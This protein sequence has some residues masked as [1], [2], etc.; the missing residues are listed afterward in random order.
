MPTQHETSNEPKSTVPSAFISYS[1]DS[2]EHREWVRDL[3]AQLRT[4]GVN[5]IL[6]RWHAVPGDQLPEFMER[7]IRENDYV[8]IVCTPKYKEKSDGRKG[9]VGYE[10]D[11]MTAE[12]FTTQNN[13]KFIPLLRMGEWRN[14]APSWLGGKYHIDLRGKP[15]SEEHYQDLLVT[16]HGRREQAPPI[17]AAPSMEKSVKRD[18]TTQPIPKSDSPDPS[19][20]ITIL[21]VIVDDITVPR[22]DG[23][24][25]SGLYAIPFRLSRRPTSEWS[26]M[27]IETWNHPP[28]FT[29]MH[30]PGIARVEGD[31][32]VLDGTTIDEVEEYHRDTLKLVVERTN[33]LALEHERIK[34]QREEQERQR[35]QTHEQKIKEAANRLKFD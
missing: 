12:V 15:Y 34:R 1:W 18:V 6:D 26:Q 3:S 2:D 10:G 33:Q 14:V 16:L 4:D 29:T 7:S 32:L 27:L 21:G 24:R 19:D 30:R 28:Q 35:L 20:P 13:R 17:G 31:K 23:T 9:G 8:L 5:V 11:I 25:G 22:N